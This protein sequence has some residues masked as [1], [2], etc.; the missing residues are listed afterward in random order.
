ML[1]SII[2][3]IKIVKYLIEEKNANIYEKYN[4]GWNVLMIA[5]VNDKMEVVKYLTEEKNVDIN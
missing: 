4:E 2:G 3:N 5:I 1:A